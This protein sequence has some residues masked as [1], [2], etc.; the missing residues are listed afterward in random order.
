M[1]KW[2]GWVIAVLA[3]LVLFAAVF[4]A[5][6]RQHAPD[7]VWITIVYEHDGTKV[8]FLASGHLY[9]SPDAGE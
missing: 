7:D 4:A 6:S 5:A 1:S 9:F 2:V 8:N 3:G